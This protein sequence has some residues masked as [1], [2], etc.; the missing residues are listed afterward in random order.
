MHEFCKRLHSVYTKSFR[1]KWP[2]TVLQ[3]MKSFLH[4]IYNVGK[5]WGLLHTESEVTKEMETPYYSSD[6]LDFSSFTPCGPA[7]LYHPSP[8]S[9]QPLPQWGDACPDLLFLTH[10]LFLPP[11]LW[12]EE[13]K[14]SLNCRPTLFGKYWARYRWQKKITHTQTHIFKKHSLLQIFLHMI[15]KI[16]GR[17][18]KKQKLYTIR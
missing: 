3:R 9:P 1:V 18:L 6:W 2:R 5:F 7:A 11:E 12:S 4:N 8:S 17:M 16:W 10:L 13:L 15:E 14:C